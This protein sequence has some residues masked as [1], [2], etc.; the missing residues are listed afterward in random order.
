MQLN[1][2]EN[3]FSF[4]ELPVKQISD[5]EQQIWKFYLPQCSFVMLYSFKLSR[6]ETELARMETIL[7]S[8]HVFK[9]TSVFILLS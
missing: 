3:F 5:K 9:I 4:Y 8:M 2:I 1:F 7:A 6:L